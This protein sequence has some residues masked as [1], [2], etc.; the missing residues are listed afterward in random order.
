LLSQVPA[1]ARERAR[2]IILSLI[3]QVR[4]ERGRPG[5][6]HPPPR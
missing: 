5:P 4:H 3:A 2:E 6:G 1:P